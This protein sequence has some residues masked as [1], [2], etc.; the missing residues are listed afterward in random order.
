MF[1]RGVR[2][3]SGRRRRPASPSAVPAD[4]APPGGKPGEAETVAEVRI[5]GNSKITLEKILAKI[6]THAGRPFNP[7]TIDEDVRSLTQ[8][9]QFISV[10]PYTLRRRRA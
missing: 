6:R 9:G 10:K 1:R 4:Q 3:R 8:N 2:R 5:T 7:S